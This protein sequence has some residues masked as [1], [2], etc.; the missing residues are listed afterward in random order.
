MKG[1]K[2]GRFFVSLPSFVFMKKNEDRHRMQ[3]EREVGR[4][5][6]PLTAL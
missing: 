2:E 4:G 1:R 6:K 5:R 3:A